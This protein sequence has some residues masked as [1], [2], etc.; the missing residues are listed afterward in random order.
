MNHNIIRKPGEILVDGQAV[1]VRSK[2]IVRENIIKVEVGTNGYKGGDSGHGSRTYF[3]IENVA[4]TDIS[5]SF[6]GGDAFCGHVTIGDLELKGRTGMTGSE[7]EADRIV[8]ELGGDAE[9][10]TFIEALEFAVAT[11]KG[12]IAR[13]PSIKE[14][15]SQAGI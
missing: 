15:L 5:L 6:A 8:I 13:Q 7:I 12:Q 11:L 2:E 10:E 14:M 9:L 3:A 4:S 1:P